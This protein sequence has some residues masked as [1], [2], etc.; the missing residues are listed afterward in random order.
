MAFSP[1]AVGRVLSD[2]FDKALL[3]SPEAFPHCQRGQTVLIAI[4]IGGSHSRQLFE[5]YSFLILDLDTNQEWLIAQR[6]FRSE[7]MR[8]MRRISFKTLNDKV[9]RRGITPFL[10]MGNLLS[11]WLVTFGISK[12]G[13]SIF[14]E[15]GTIAPELECLLESWKP[16][17]QERLMRV[18]HLSAF[19]MSGLCLDRQNILWVID[20]DEITSNVD[21]L[22]R[23]TRLLA[24]VYSS[25]CETPLGHLRCATAK[26]D[27]GTRTL[28]DLI[29][30]CD[31]AAGAVCEIG[32]AMAGSHQYLQ[33]TIIAPL[34]SFL[35]W[36]SRHICSWLAYDRSP[37]RRFTCLI[38]LKKDVPGMKVQ[39]IRWHALPGSLQVPPD[40][41]PAA[42]T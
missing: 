27:D 4:D 1:H 37:L 17:V 39:M 41:D 9:R 21:Q 30:Y 32:T 33:R 20:E 15:R 8:S 5:T 14:Q 26:S 12:S 10:Q 36:K 31:L 18:L 6:A 19:L 24:H 11:G 35:S 40:H 42:P 34:P 2:S 23:L 7:L 22:T 38:D 25:A 29:A 28:E 16:T 3:K 13:E